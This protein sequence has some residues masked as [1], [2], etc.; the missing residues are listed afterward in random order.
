MLTFERGLQFVAELAECVV[1]GLVVWD[2][3]R[4]VPRPTRVLEEVFTR[5]DGRIH[6]RQQA[7]RCNPT[8][9]HSNELLSAP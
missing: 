8:A 2:D 5:V 7:R 6:R 3:V 4:A 9:T 1:A